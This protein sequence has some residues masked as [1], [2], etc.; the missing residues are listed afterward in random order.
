MREIRPLPIG[1]GIPFRQRCNQEE[2]GRREK[3][4]PWLRVFFAPTRLG[5]DSARSDHPARFFYFRRRSQPFVVPE[6][7]VIDG[8]RGEGFY[9]FSLDPAFYGYTTD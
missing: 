7:P 3:K 4:N 8:T 9:L 5:G 1:A 2:E 6:T